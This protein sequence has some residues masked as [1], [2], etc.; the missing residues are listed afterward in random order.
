[1]WRKILEAMDTTE[2]VAVT[3]L[4]IRFYFLEVLVGF[5]AGARFHA[6]DCGFTML[7][8]A[9]TP[10]GPSMALICRAIS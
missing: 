4:P 3:I 1:M 5:C 9:E 2:S 6:A 7:I 8:A 10:E